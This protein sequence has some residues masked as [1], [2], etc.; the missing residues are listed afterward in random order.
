MR[1]SL[2]INGLILSMLL[3]ADVAGAAG[4]GRLSVMSALGQPL[5]AEIELLSMPQE[6]IGSLSAKLA[7]AEA[8]RQARMDRADALNGLQFNIA[9]RPG[10]QPVLRI[11]S[12]A[13]VSDPF[14]D[15]LIELNWSSGRI[16]R[17]YTVLLDPPRDVKAGAEA[18]PQVP[19][20]SVSVQEPAGKGPVAAPADDAVK[21][22]GNNGKAGDAAR[23]HAPD[24]P[25]G[26]NV[27][28]YGPVKSG[29]TLRSIASKVRHPEVSIEMMMA[30]LYQ[31][32]KKAF[33]RDNINLLKKGQTLAVPEPD[34]FAKM[35]S[36]GEARALIREHG[37]AWNAYRAQVAESAAHAPMPEP[38]ADKK[39]ESAAGKIVPAPVKDKAAPAPAPGAD[40]LKLSKGQP[41][42]D[43]ASQQRQQALEEEVAAKGRSLK[44]ANERVAQLEKTVKDMQQLIK[45]KDQQAK[46]PEAAAPAVEEK[47]AV[48]AVETA[49]AVKPPPAAEEPGFIAM[50][51]EKPLYIGGAV[52]AI[53]LGILGWMLIGRRRHN[54]MAHLEQ[55]IIN[56]GDDFKTAIFRTTA[57]A[58]SQA[59]T[60]QPSVMTDF[61]RLGL[62]AIDT[63]E[64]DPIAEAEVYMAYGRDAQAEEILKEALNR[65]SGRHE[66]ALKL[67][68]IYASRG[69]TGAFETQASEIYAA[70][71]G[72]PTPL[73]Q[74]VT[75]LGRSIDPTNPLYQFKGSGDA[76]PVVPDESPYPSTAEA[77]REMSMDDFAESRDAGGDTAFSTNTVDDLFTDAADIAH[78]EESAPS[79]SD[80]LGDVIDFQM[81]MDTLNQDADDLA[82][83]DLDLQTGETQNQATDEVDDAFPAFDMSDFASPEAPPA[84]QIASN[85]TPFD[86]HEQPESQ[87]MADLDFSGIDLELSEPAPTAPLIENIEMEM[88]PAA[89]EHLG[90]SSDREEDIDP[91][92]VEEV[93]TKLDLA[94]A[95]LEMGD[96]EGA[97]EILEEALQE[98][99]RAQKTLARD[100]LASSA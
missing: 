9:Q 86:E 61:S 81:D 16:L 76:F 5:K 40:V 34:S 7:S 38:A 46:G 15:L 3:L 12:S 4:L 51:L 23:P 83:M 100:L 67:L 73:W 30:G 52:A 24:A 90:D 79:V 80:D 82:V 48:P 55:S 31:S 44:E 71:S 58:A 92:I 49:E 47:P 54:S 13:P 1:K 45:L 75:D 68:E 59:N 19:V 98:G 11:S 20:Q 56:S 91:E 28:A 57:G 78:A 26:V 64:V 66:I 50:L 87:P 65:D 29:E 89:V 8:F 39:K 70:L 14:L 33:A 41:G 88:P 37:V 2:R 72:E 53:L 99:N 10:G 36:Q 22:D 43:A 62:G 21:P 35:F 27:S 17:E 18:T 69:D 42:A 74:K 84:N 25:S 96:K 32:N 85:R 77:L 97:R 6:E 94:K 60:Q 63:H 95:Y 93:N